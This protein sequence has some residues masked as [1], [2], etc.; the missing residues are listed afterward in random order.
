MQHV[1][2]GDLLVSGIPATGVGGSGANYVFTFPQPP[3]G[4]AEIAWA[5][6]HGITDFGYPTNLA[7]NELSPDAQWEPVPIADNARKTAL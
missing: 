6:G 7:F 3:Y 5:N 2:A 4:E 1:D